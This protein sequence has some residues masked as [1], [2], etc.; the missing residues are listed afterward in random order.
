[1]RKILAVITLCVMLLS[2]CGANNQAGRNATSTGTAE[3][4]TGNNATTGSTS[5]S[6]TPSTL[7]AQE[8]KVSDFFPFESN[9]H[10]KYKG[11]G[12]EYAQYE[13]YVDYIRGNSMQVRENNGGTEAV[14]VY[15]VKDGALV[16]TYKRA[17]TYYKYD[18]TS[19]SDGDDILLKEPIAVGTSWTAKDGS[20]RSI[21][22][23]DRV[24]ETPAGKFTAIEVTTKRSNS[25]DK[26]YYAKG[27]GLVK[28]EYLSGDGSAAVTSELEKVEKG[29]PFK[30]VV[31]FYYPQFLKDR[32]VYM[33]RE[34]EI[35]TNEDMRYKFQKELKIIPA[36]GGLTKTFTKNTKILGYSL[37][38]KKDTVTV[39]LSS[40]FVR[41]MNAG[42]GLE[43]MLLNSVTNT[44]GDY[45][46]KSKV[47]ITLDGKPYESGHVMMK[48]GEAFKVK[49]EGIIQFK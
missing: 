27:T 24:V 47:I 8:A 40:D 39:D 34:I 3:S 5:T 38:D 12:N 1:M 46:M 2:A 45:Y 36:S 28:I 21:T 22:A 19:M 6:E 17:E 48:P 11:T 37:D 35:K 42:A 30:Q 18:Y 14:I 7:A 26:S 43:G 15:A 41:E 13:T 25:T 49:K 10:M 29:V 4:S 23:V 44:F 32:I 33:E 20:A 9:V 16:S 31:R